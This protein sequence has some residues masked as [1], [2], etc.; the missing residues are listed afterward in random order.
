MSPGPASALVDADAEVAV[1]RLP[2]PIPPR[3][4]LGSSSAP[5]HALPEAARAIR[6]VGRKLDQ[7]GRVGT[8][9]RRASGRR[10]CGVPPGS[11]P[12]PACRPP[13]PSAPCRSATRPRGGPAARSASVEPTRVQ[14]LTLPLA[15]SSTSA[16]RPKAKASAAAP[17]TS[18]TTALSQPLAQALD[19]GLEV[20]LVLLGD[21]VLGVLLEVALLAGG[22]DPRRHRLPPRPFELLDLLAQGL[23]AL[24][25]IGSPVCS[26]LIGCRL[27]RTRRRPMLYGRAVRLRP[28]HIST[29]SGSSTCRPRSPAARSAWP[30]G[31][32]LG[33]SA[34]V[35]GLRPHR[36]LRQLGGQTRDRPLR[37][38]RAPDRPLGRAGRGLE[39][40][41][42]RR[43]DVPAS[44][45]E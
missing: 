35:P 18:T 42:R 22:L 2:S 45:P 1:A 41:L 36:L 28:A 26:A 12:R 5:E 16:V 24:S 20:R 43:A 40:V 10:R 37:G 38:D 34:D 44:A 4:R 14:V 39:L 25:V 31:M 23:D 3:R 15:S 21:V 9:S 17:S 33:P 19:P 27:S 8:A 7:G 6:V 32:P 30:S 29:R 11:R 13:R